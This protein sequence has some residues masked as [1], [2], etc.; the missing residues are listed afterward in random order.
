MLCM[1]LVVPLVALVAGLTD[2]DPIGDGGDASGMVLAPDLGAPTRN[3]VVQQQRA[4]ALTDTDP[5]VEWHLPRNT[6]RPQ[7]A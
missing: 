3:H 4:C 5:L 6:T 2:T 1:A 7:K